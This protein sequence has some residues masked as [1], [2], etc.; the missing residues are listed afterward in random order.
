[1][2]S[3]DRMARLLVIEDDV[4]L[5]DAL[6]DTLHNEGFEVV[7]FADPALARDALRA[8]EFDLLLSDLMMPG[9]DGI[10]LLEQA[11]RI[12]PALVGVI[13][14]GQGSIPTAIEAMRAGAVDFILKPFQRQQILSA[15]DRAM[16]VRRMKVENDRL[17]REVER[18][19]A[20]RVRL[21][22]ETNARLTAL[23]TTDPLT[24][25]AN[26]RAFDEAL[27]REVALA[28]RGVHPVSLVVLDV[29]HFKG[30]NDTF[31]HQVGDEVLRQVAS[32]ARGCCRATD[33]A[34]RFGG[35]EFTVLL[36]ATNLD[37]AIALAERIR[38]AVAVG[39]WSLRPVT[40]SA[41]VATLV[42]GEDTAG[43]IEAA[44]RAMY[45]AKRNGRNRVES[46]RADASNSDAASRR[47]SV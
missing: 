20:E 38:Q 33:L 32:A 18:L 12:D 10:Q 47:S 23:A 26:R 9:T 31:G 40:V 24:G 41:G 11:L 1:M 45:R 29:D 37:G 17:R 3:P 25:L 27:A 6:R 36:P 43:L 15:L 19:E 39:P 14:T 4:E 7:G 30:F 13:M 42:S 8:G 2:S 16:S 44:D 21:L 46:D 34:T 35:E 22:E 5:L 28:E